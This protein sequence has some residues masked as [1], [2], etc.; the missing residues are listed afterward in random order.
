MFM[1]I[2]PCIYLHTSAP[3]VF[4]QSAMQLNASLAPE[5]AMDGIMVSLVRSEW[6]AACE[7]S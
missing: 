5:N 4:F 1:F 2:W 7:V 6:R 3:S